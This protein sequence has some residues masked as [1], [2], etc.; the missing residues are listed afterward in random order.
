MKNQQH[1]P[2]I[3]IG[4]SLILLTLFGCQNQQD[5][6][7][8]PTQ[9]Q[10]TQNTDGQTS[11]QQNTQP[12]DKTQTQ[13]QSQTQIQTQETQ[14]LTDPFHKTDDYWHGT[15]T[16]TG[17]LDIEK[18]VCNPGD[19]CGKTV[20]YASFIFTKADQQSVYDFIKE[21][22]GNAA[23]DAQK[24]GLGCY[25]KNKNTIE[26]ENDASADGINIDTIHTV[27]SGN[28]LK[29]LL[30]SNKQNQVQLQAT[31]PINKSG[32]GAPDCYSFLRN[33]KML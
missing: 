9:T 16:L 23:L 15:M 7:P 11:T 33:F 10:Q 5:L 13:S 28:D 3:V 31:M 19:M 24:I 29:K 2:L 26:S 27:I 8:A 14:N 25:D 4:S 21:F 17:Y 18:R 6:Q 1:L 30:A 22:A 32:R 20:D 12:V